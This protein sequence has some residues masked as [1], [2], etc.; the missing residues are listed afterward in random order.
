MEEKT[1]KALQNPYQTSIM[2]FFQMQ[3]KVQKKKKHYSYRQQED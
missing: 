1:L 3:K 2:S